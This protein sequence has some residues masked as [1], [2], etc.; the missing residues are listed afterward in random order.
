MDRPLR[1]SSSGGDS[2]DEAI[3]VLFSLVSES[4]G[5][6]TSALLDQDFE[7]ANRVIS[8]DEDIDRHCEELT[9]AVKERLADASA[10]PEVLENLVSILQIVPE[11][12]RSADLA[13]HIAQ[14]SL[15]GLGGVITP[16]SRGLIQAASEIALG[17]W[18]GAGVAYIK[19]SR[20]ASFQLEESDNELDDLC[21]ALVAEG[22]SQGDDP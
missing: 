22:L 13:K 11:L 4:L 10:E 8:G 9:A 21:A 16:R 12:E 7:G 14:R 5:W 15:E 17:M 6:A 20:D 2:L 19:R 3:G 18:Q 1:R